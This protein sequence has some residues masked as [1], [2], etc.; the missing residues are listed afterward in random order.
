MPL[1][2]DNFD[3]VGTF[4]ENW[5]QQ[6]KVEN[7]NGVVKM[8]NANITMKR[9]LPEE[10]VASMRLSLQE[11][12]DK[13]KTGFGGF[14]IG[15]SKFMLRP[16]GMAW[17]VY[18][19]P[20][21]TRSKGAIA[22]IDGFQFGKAYTLTLSG[23]KLNDAIQYTYQVDGKNIG[24]AVMAYD[25]NAKLTIFAY[26]ESITVDDFQLFALKKGDDSPNVVVNSSFEHL[27]EGMPIYFDT[28]TLRSFNFSKPYK[29]YLKTFAVDDREKHSGKYSLRLIFNDSCD[30]QG[31]QTWDTG[32]V[33][34]QPMTFSVWLKADQDKTPARLSIWEMRTKWHHKE[35]ILS[36]EWQR[37]EF[38]LPAATQSSVRVGVKL[39][40]PGTV[41]ADDLQ[42]EIADKATPYKLSSL[43]VDKFAAKNDGKKSVAPLF[44]KELPSAPA[45][46]GN[47]D[48]WKD[49]SWH[50]DKF[51]FKEGAPQHQTDLY[52]GCD[53]ENLYVG[54]RSFFS[55][56]KK[57]KDQKTGYDDFKIF[58]QDNI[59]ILPDPGR[60][61]KYYYQ[62]V[63]SAAGSR[64]DL[65]HGRNPKWNGE[66]EAV[67]KR[68]ENL[69]SVDYE[70][71]IPFA[72]L[73]TPGAAND[74]GLNIGRSDTITKQATAIMPYHEPNFHKVSEYPVLKLPTEIVKKYAL[75]ITSAKIS[76]SGNGLYTVSGIFE[77]NSGS[78]VSGTLSA[79]KAG[80]K[81]ESGKIAVTFKEG[82]NHFS[83]TLSG[84]KL[85]NSEIVFTLISDNKVRSVQYV[86]PELF[87]PLSIVSKYNYYMNDPIAEFRISCSMN[88][89][90]QLRAVLKCGSVKLESPADGNLTM[91]LP[92]EKIAVGK[93][94]V[95]IELFDKDRKIAEAKTELIKKE[96]RKNAVRINQF[97]RCLSSGEKNIL[98]FAPLFD[99]RPE[100]KNVEK[101]VE[102]L[103]D[104][105]FKYAMIVI[106]RN[107]IENGDK[108]IRE[109]EKHG[110]K[111][112]YWEYLSK[113]CTTDD[114]LRDKVKTL[115][116]YNN[117]IAYLILDE[118]ELYMKSDEAK[119]ILTKIRPMFPYHPT[120]MNNTVL[121]IPNRFADLSTDILML[122]DYLTNKEN[123]T[124]REIVDQVEIMWKAGKNE[125]KPCYYFLAGNNMHNHYREP[126][127]NEQ[128]AQTYGSIASGCTGFA[129]FM[130]VPS[131]P[132]HW[133]AYKALNREILDLND[134][135]L[136]DEDVS[137][138]MLSDATIKYITRK[139]QGCLYVISAN[140]DKRSSDDVKITLPATLRY[141][142]NVE[143]MFENR[144]IK[145]KNGTFSDSFSPLSRHVYKVKIAK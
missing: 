70:V 133:K 125:H 145:L 36:Q 43:D 55:D 7:A 48:S 88:K 121:G 45:M 85:E 79:T 96:Y 118:P 11:P 29:K 87:S 83:L 135:I 129:Y 136:S 50:T 67:A 35:V 5:K 75:G 111:V 18:K 91:K 84:D 104:N 109:A 25:K 94:D 32:M 100:Y 47:L 127:S 8:R 82:S 66:W 52:L 143:V 131:F 106:C 49:K 124:V 107:A 134:I 137:D 19:I 80:N 54:V 114:S 53:K 126:T 40:K 128:Y 37:Y 62:L 89:P 122:D 101:K 97:R 120:F 27:Q 130:G 86:R 9:D 64:T 57:I 14:D 90:E 1:F 132:E 138:A 63:A 119:S 140:I 98:P 12:E 112:I 34:G 105:G 56:M 26:R 69:G 44:V 116:G 142:E 144:N 38:T 103:A 2:S 117:N 102:F 28:D 22:K 110:I 139:H 41:W 24:S 73:A 72:L 6:G 23:K 76:K 77:N 65:G 3:V 123:R 20:G 46:D 95:S 74:W 17:M 93:H 78:T 4:A 13:S 141:S 81:D 58:G 92:L 115:H 68:N 60:S 61:K 59:E 16:D 108:F 99:I 51:Y 39:S 21:E 30:R 33:V 15:G 113:S 42:V 10:F 31:F 71:R